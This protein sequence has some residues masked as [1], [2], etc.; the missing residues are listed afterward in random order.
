M[1]AN[2]IVKQHK[3][4]QVGGHLIEHYQYD[5]TVSFSGEDRPV[6]KKFGNLLR[7]AGYR[8]FYDMWEQ[9]D[10]WG[11]NLYEYLDII[12]RQAAR[13]C[14]VFI[15]NNYIRNAWAK[16]GLRSAQARAFEQSSE[17]ILPLLLDDTQLPG[18]PSRIAY[19]DLRKHSVEEAVTLLASKLSTTD[20]PNS[21]N[22]KLRSP[23]IEKWIHALN[24]IAINSYSTCIDT[25]MV[26]LRTDE[27]PMVRGRAA[28]ALDNLK[29]AVRSMF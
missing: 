26:L 16:H 25:V 14:V 9:H 4:Y 22:E 27:N 6:V 2:H 11:K 17:Y 12:Y 21:I 13:Y 19:F 18:L 5:V 28:W 1:L 15:S 20:V 24:E 3:H 7:D 29:I 10:I 23:N 8:V